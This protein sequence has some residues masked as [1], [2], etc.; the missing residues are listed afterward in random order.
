MSGGDRTT[1][2]RRRLPVPPA[3]AGLGR[4]RSVFPVVRAV[5]ARGCGIARVYPFAV[6]ADCVRGGLPPPGPIYRFVSRLGSAAPAGPVVGLAAVVLVLQVGSDVLAADPSAGRPTSGRRTIAN[7][8]G[9]VDAVALAAVVALMGAQSLPSTVWAAAVVVAAVRIDRWWASRPRVG[10]TDG[11]QAG[12]GLAVEA[13][14]AAA[15]LSVVQW[16]GPQAVAA[17]AAVHKARVSAQ[18]AVRRRVG[19]FVHRLS[20]GLVLTWTAVGLGVAGQF[21]LGRTTLSRSI[22]S[23]P[24]TVGEALIVVALSAA[25]FRLARS[26]GWSAA[27]TPTAAAGRGLDGGRGDSLPVAAPLDR[28]AP[29]GLYPR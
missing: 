24:L 8:G 4:T 15:V 28:P 16:L 6:L 11:G 29:R 26:L 5:A 9:G 20:P 3:F 19:R 1:F 23:R 17:F 18:M 22:G 27:G 25:A 14:R 10:P 13:A 12:A 2:E 7:G 21:L